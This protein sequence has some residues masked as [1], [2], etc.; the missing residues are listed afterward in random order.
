MVAQTL[1][2]ESLADELPDHIP[3]RALTDVVMDGAGS[4]HQDDHRFDPA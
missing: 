3:P 1:V 2:K 4:G